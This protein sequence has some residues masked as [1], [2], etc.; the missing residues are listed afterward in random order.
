MDFNLS[1]EQQMFRDLFRDFAEKEVAPVAEHTD[2]T[3]APPAAVLQ[4]A[5]A[6]GFLGAPFPEALGGAAMD[7]LTYCLLLEALAQQCAS[8]AVTVAVHTSLAGLTL[9]EA[10]T[11]AQKEAYLPRLAGGELGA[12]ALTEPDAG[13]DT[14]VLQTRAV[15]ANGG[16]HFDGVKS[17]V[18]NGGTAGLYLVFAATEPGKGPAGL[19]A[20]IVEKSAPYLVVGHREPTLGLRGLDVRTLYLEGGP[21]PEG[22]LLGPLNGGWALAQRAQDRFKLALAAVS[23]GVAENALA[24][25]VRF[26]VE[27]KQFGTAIAQKGAIQTYL[28]DCATEI[29]SVRHLVHHAAWLA[30][31]GQ[32]YA[33][34]AAMAKYLGARVAKDTANKM[35]QVHGGYGFSDE[36]AISRVYRDSRALKIVGGTDEVQRFLVAQAVLQE[37]GVAIQP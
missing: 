4:K 13:S 12:F 21:L 10:G 35:L 8:T 6:Q 24:L 34:A 26:A 16:W 36:Y 23:L 7:Q 25:G 18:S 9:L 19:S 31:Q 15:L 20:F 33:R 32:P 30:D 28:A 14:S 1:E 29:E 3:E 5:A 22:E 37:A 27:R 2:H 17:W 11:A